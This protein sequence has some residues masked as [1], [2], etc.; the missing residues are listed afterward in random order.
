M[1]YNFL[2]FPNII[3]FRYKTELKTEHS[4]IMDGKENQLEEFEAKTLQLESNLK[5]L[6]D[7]REEA[8]KVVAEREDVIV[9]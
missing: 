5:A 7:E 3:S 1:I 2:S 8:L 9:R 6:A 4:T